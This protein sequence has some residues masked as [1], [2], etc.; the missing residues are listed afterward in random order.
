MKMLVTKLEQL[1]HDRF[2][3]VGEKGRVLA[4]TVNVPGKGWAIRDED[5]NLLDD[6]H[7][8]DPGRVRDFFEDMD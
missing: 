5:G 1:T 6:R 4:L 8:H 7:F 2:K 3:V